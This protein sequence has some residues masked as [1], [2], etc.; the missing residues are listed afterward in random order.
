VRS[1][2]TSEI[3]RLRVRVLTNLPE[4][5]AKWSDEGD[6]ERPREPIGLMGSLQVSWAHAIGLVGKLRDERGALLSGPGVG[7]EGRR[8]LGAAGVWGLAYS[9]SGT[10][11]TSLELSDDSPGT[12]ITVGNQP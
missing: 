10:A 4:A 1:A 2:G 9:G 11:A 12:T 7:V 8:G 6:V 3:Q 5:K